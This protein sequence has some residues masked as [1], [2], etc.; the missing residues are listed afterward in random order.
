MRGNATCQN[1]TFLHRRSTLLTLPT[2]I[3]K[4]HQLGNKSLEKSVIFATKAS[5]EAHTQATL[6]RRFPASVIVQ[7]KWVLSRGAGC[8][9]VV[10]LWLLW[11]KGHR[12]R[13]GNPRSQSSRSPWRRCW[14]QSGTASDRPQPYRRVFGAA[15]TPIANI[16]TRVVVRTCRKYEV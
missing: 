13:R 5:N 12:S 10:F 9:I 2:K 1:Q 7:S 14:D 6:A 4:M 16:R 15:A 8:T 11:L 3:E